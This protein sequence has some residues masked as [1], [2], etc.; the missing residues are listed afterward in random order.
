MMNMV[1]K[2]TPFAVSVRW[3]A[4]AKYLILEGIGPVNDLSVLKPSTLS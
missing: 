2:V 3:P 4:L 1:N